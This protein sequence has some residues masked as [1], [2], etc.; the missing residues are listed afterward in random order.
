MECGASGTEVDQLDHRLT[1]VE[2][3]NAVQ[4]A[5]L[6]HTTETFATT[7]PTLAKNPGRAALYNALLPGLGY[8]YLGLTHTAITALLL[9]ALFIA[10]SFFFFRRRA[11]AAAVLFLSFEVGWYVGGIQGGNSQALTFNERTYEALANPLMNQEGIFPI[12]LL[13]YGL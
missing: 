1:H 13:R 8:Y 9:N 10:S 12:H 7:Y 6:A 3:P 2:S 11:W 5:D 4:T